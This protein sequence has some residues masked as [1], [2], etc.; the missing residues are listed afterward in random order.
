MRPRRDAEALRGR[1]VRAGH[2]RLLRAPIRA[3]DLGGFAAPVASEVD[4]VARRIKNMLGVPF[5]PNE[6]DLNE[7]DAS[8]METT[9]A[10]NDL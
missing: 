8:E 4:V 6:T 7:T 9:N 2:A 10:K 1:L 5:D 3:T